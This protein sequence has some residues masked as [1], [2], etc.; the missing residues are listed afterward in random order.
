M[1]VQKPG[2]SKQDYGTPIELI[3]AVTRR[4]GELTTDLAAHDDGSNAKC[5][6]WIGESKNSLEQDWLYEIGF[7]GIG[8]L[9]PP[10]AD[11]NPWAEKCKLESRKGARIIMLTPASVGA[12]WF[13]RHVEDDN[14]GRGYATMIVPLRPRI[15]FEGAKDPY[16]KDCCLTLWGFMKA[17]PKGMFMP[18]IP[19]GSW[20]WK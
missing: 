20:R 6:R 9:N 13:A 12:E 8:W 16:P 15:T 17:D 19:Y 4:F 5:A 7:G 10:F 2:K 11:I 14:E 1:P 3:E 18:V